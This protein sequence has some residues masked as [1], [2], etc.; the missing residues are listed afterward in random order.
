[1]AQM[2]TRGRWAPVYSR[3]KSGHPAN[4]GYKQEQIHQILD[5]LR[6][7]LEKLY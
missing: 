1:M 4:M 3:P 5:E 6:M 7:A 2:P